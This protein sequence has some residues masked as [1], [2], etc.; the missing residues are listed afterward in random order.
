MKIED[1]KKV[2]DFMLTEVAPAADN[3]AQTAS[4]EKEIFETG[5]HTETETFPRSD[6]PGPK[7]N[8]TNPENSTFSKMTA[9]QAV[10][11]K[12]AV[13]FADFVIP[14]L[15]AMLAKFSGYELDKKLL[16]LNKDDRDLLE[17]AAQDYLNSIDLRLTPFQALL[18]AISTVYGSKVVEILPTLKP[19][20]KAPERQP[21]ATENSQVSE[22]NER[23]KRQAEKRAENE[24]FIKAVLAAGPEAGA[25]M[26]VDKKKVAKAKAR[27]IYNQYKAAK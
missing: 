18:V 5:K 26:I 3:P 15:F 27:Q 25:L 8:P 7:D 9:G 1:L 22:A 2:P 20:K 19:L 12:T 23:L 21:A 14:A 13:A 10:S 24:A 17:P 6:S 16:K 4:P 11:G